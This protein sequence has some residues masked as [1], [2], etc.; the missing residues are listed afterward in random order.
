M[1]KRSSHTRTARAGAATR[2]HRLREDAGWE[3][4]A[5][6]GSDI[7][8]TQIP[9]GDL[10]PQG[11]LAPRDEPAP[12]DDAV[13]WGDVESV[14]AICRRHAELALASPPE[15]RETRLAACRV[16]WIS[17]ATAFNC[18]PADQRHF[19]DELVDVTRSLMAELPEPDPA[20]PEAEAQPG[21]AAPSPGAL[22]T[23][24]ELRPLLQQI[25]RQ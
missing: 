5:W 19:A 17:Y 21:S 9:Q 16:V 8:P 3:N 6:A 20:P 14:L 24:E 10:A 18:S 4:P 15:A 11:E 13:L 23:I 12:Q 1:S 25:I 7:A 22:L 2:P